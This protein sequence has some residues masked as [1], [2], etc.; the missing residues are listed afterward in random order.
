MQIL[1]SV[2]FFFLSNKNN[3]FNSLKKI[4]FSTNFYNKSLFTKIPKQFYFYPRPNLLF[5]FNREMNFH[6]KL[7][8]LN[9]N[10]F[11]QEQKTE[12]D[13]KIVN[14]FEWLYLINRKNDV[15]IIQRLISLWIYKNRKYKKKTWENSLISKRV[16]S[17]ILNADIILN[18]TN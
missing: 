18:N 16:I 8:K 1:K 4:Y 12:R 13:D 14:S 7:S 9:T 11:W 2:Y 17:W 3:F 10:E 5:S 6:F 15:L